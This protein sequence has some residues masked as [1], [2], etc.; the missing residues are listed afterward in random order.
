MSEFQ[1]S[2]F[3]VTVEAALGQHWLGSL[4][5]CSVV[6][7]S[8]QV[9]GRCCAAAHAKSCSLEKRRGGLL[10][11]KTLLAVSGRENGK[12]FSVTGV[13][14]QKIHVYLIKL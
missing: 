1:V 6:W 5:G 2:Y 14:S 4:C 9:G 10:E 11:A 8:G 3:P 7:L 12:A 13:H